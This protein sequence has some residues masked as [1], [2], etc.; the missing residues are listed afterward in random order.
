MVCKMSL[1]SQ[2][3]PIII[4]GWSV[5]P[6]CTFIGTFQSFNHSRE[7]QSLTNWSWP[8]LLSCSVDVG[9]KST[10]NVHRSIQATSALAISS[11]T[12]LKGL[13]RYLPPQ[14][15]DRERSLPVPKGIM[16]IAGILPFG[17]LMESIT[18]NIQPTVPSPPQAKI[19]NCSC[20]QIEQHSSLFVKK[21][22]A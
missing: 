21:C 17:K 20:N 1:F 6:H 22:M 11:N 5:V 18:D 9:S 7:D 4:F 12:F 8:C 10:F 19:E 13:S 14:L 15:R 2:L 3:Q 16:P